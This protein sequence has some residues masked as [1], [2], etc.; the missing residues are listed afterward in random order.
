MKM[1]EIGKHYRLPKKDFENRLI[2]VFMKMGRMSKGRHTENTLD[3]DGEPTTS[4]M[5]LYHVH[6]DEDVAKEVMDPG[7]FNLLKNDGDFEMHIATWESGVG[8]IVN[9]TGIR[10]LIIKIARAYP[11]PQPCVNCDIYKERIERVGKD[12]W[13]VNETC[14]VCIM[15]DGWKNFTMNTQE[16]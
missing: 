15:G 3:K 10:K 16:E 13:A 7:D 1:L 2:E 6:L 12:H 14:E 11:E 8:W 5:T 4:L 9:Y